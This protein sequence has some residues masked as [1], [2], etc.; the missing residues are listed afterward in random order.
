MTLSWLNARRISEPILE[1]ID[2]ADCIRQGE[3]RVQIPTFKGQ[4][5]LASLSQSL[6][7]MV[8]TLDDQKQSLIDELE[9]S[10]QTEAELKEQ[11]EQLQK[12]STIFQS[13]WLFS[14]EMAKSNGSTVNGK[15]Y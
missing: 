9:Q 2:V 6:V 10:Q 1:L 15:E 4:D 12:L 3:D 13:C 14:I 7:Y 5:E 8:S 11:Q